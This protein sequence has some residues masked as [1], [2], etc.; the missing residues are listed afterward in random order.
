MKHTHTHDEIYN[1]VHNFIAIL[2]P[3]YSFE[4]KYIPV[5]CSNLPDSTHSETILIFLWVAN[6]LSSGDITIDDVDII[7]ILIYSVVMMS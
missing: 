4:Q 7:S 2:V 5:T 3:I 1:L 6:T